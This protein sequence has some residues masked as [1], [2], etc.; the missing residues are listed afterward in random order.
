MQLFG[1]PV[2]YV[3]HVITTDN[4]WHINPSTQESG[5]H[6]STPSKII[7]IIDGYTPNITKP[8]SELYPYLS[9]DK[10]WATRSLKSKK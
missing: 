9:Y 5:F 6:P 3:N 8:D 1:A 4:I 10:V 7:L 2:V